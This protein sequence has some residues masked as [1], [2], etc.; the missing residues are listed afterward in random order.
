MKTYEALH[1]AIAGKTIEHARALHLS[2]SLVGKWQE[3]TADW[4]DSGAHNPL[5]RI[6]A[7]IE[8]AIKQGN[9]DALAPIQYLAE[10]FGLLIIPVPKPNGC[11]ADVSLE[12][13]RTVKE[14]GEMASVAS[15]ALEDA[16]LTRKEAEQIRKEAFELMRQVAAFDKKAHEAAI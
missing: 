6:E 5:D 8:T 12:L 11:M 14:F 9:K 13:M 1:A 4:T 3:P 16:K 7:I 15:A 10:K 2:A